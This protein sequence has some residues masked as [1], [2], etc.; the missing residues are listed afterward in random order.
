M[1]K[2]KTEEKPVVKAEEK[3]RPLKVKVIGAGGIGL[4]VL[5]PLCMFLNYSEIPSI[6]LSVIDGDVYEERNRE[7][8]AF[9]KIGP[10]ATVT[11]NRLK[12]R[13]PKILFWDHPVFVTEGNV[14]NLIREHDVIMMCVDNHNTRKLISDRAEELDN[15][16]LISGGNDYTDGN[17]LVHVR[18]NG[19]D[20]TLPI[21]NKYHEEIV[22]PKDKHPGEIAALGCQAMVATEPQLVFTNNLVAAH[23][24]SA[25]YGITQKGK[26]DKYNEVYVDLITNNSKALLRK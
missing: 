19:K 20:L 4:F 25:F 7:R 5:E 13:Y 17:L 3:K 24:L 6:E 12:D 21:A 14:I 9:D 18:R 11:V 16:T 10:K 22:K 2:K 15:V 26:E 1:A 8:Q 23:M